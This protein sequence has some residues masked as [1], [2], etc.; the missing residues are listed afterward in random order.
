ME[1]NTINDT[2]ITTSSTLEDS[3]MYSGKYARLNAQPIELV[4]AGAWIAAVNDPA[5]FI[6]VCSMDDRIK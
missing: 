4:S 3:E 6:E 1:D 2:Q 5:P